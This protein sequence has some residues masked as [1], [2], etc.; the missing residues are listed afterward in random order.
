MKQTRWQAIRDLEEWKL[1][2]EERKANVELLAEENRTMMMDPSTMD[3][4]TREW[5]DMRR[6]EI[7][8]RRR[9][10]MQEASASMHATTGGGASLAP[11]SGG[12]TGEAMDDD[13]VA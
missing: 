2:L 10:V 7:I 3:A 8:A 1:A 5:W 6:M 13:V 9:Q 11:A 12:A 4:Y